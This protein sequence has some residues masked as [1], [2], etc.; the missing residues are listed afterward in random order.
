M[1]EMIQGLSDFTAREGNVASMVVVSVN[2]RH[3][4]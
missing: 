4:C 1:V 3:F 2:V